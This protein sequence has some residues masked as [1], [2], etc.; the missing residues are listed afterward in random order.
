MNIGFCRWLLG[1][2]RRGD[3][4]RVMFHEVRYHMEPGDRP[5]RLLRP[6]VHLW[7]ARILLRASS[8]VYVSIPEW[9][10]ML[11]PLAPRPSPPILWT[12]VPSNIPSVDDP[13]G[14]AEVRRRYAPSGETLIG[15]FGTFRESVRK[16]LAAV[17]PPLLAKPGR[18]AL[19]IG[20]GGEEFAAGM[21]ADH[22]GLAGRIAATGGIAA[23]DVAR[24]LRACDL[25]VQVDPGGVCSKQT[26]TMA[27]LANGR[28]I[29]AAEGR[30]TEPVWR[31]ERCVALA[32]SVDPAALLGVAEACLAEPVELAR[33]ERAAREAY[34][35]H[36]SIAR[37]IATISDAAIA[38]PRGAS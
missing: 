17:L 37:T 12:P 32:S 31:E 16:I 14:S 21:T 30:L 19:L 38:I 5:I 33:L 36:F 20:R 15:V 13:E 25:L 7:M 23:G 18:A 2:R 10:E 4:V 22:A 6:P 9:A 26:T 11:R 8:R 3:D 29:L 27:G 24:H 1:R 34:D 28:A 35:R